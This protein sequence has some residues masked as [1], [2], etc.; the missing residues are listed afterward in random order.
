M[1]RT[2]KMMILTT[3]EGKE[4][5]IEEFKKMGDH[6]KITFINEE[7]EELIYWVRI[8]PKKRLVMN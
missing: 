5:R 8:T 2:T 3:S 6:L 4:Y 7:K 1:T